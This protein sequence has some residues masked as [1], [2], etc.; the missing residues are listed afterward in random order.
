MTKAE[1]ERNANVL[2]TAGSE[3]TATL[4]SGATYLL[5]KNPRVWDKLRA[6][7]RGR[8]QSAD[9]INIVS[10]NQLPYLF[11]VLEESHRLYPPI[12]C[13]LPRVTGPEGDVIDSRFVPGG[14]SICMA[15]LLD[16]L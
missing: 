8:F 9:E 11:A 3:T 6:E 12:P 14:V 10:T 5:M 16:F 7:I 1:I 2:I 4:L 13:L 15:L